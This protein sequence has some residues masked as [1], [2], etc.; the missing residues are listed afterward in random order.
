[1]N[2][3]K[4][5]LLAALAA[6]PLVCRGNTESLETVQPKDAVTSDLPEKE[7]DMP[8]DREPSFQGGRRR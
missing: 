1:M 5:I 4:C 8:Q 6:A 2:P 7:A 3:L